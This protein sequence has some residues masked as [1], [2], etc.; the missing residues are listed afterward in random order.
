[1]SRLSVAALAALSVPI[2][3]LS[4][5][6]TG[7]AAAQSAESQEPPPPPPGFESTKGETARSAWLAAT[8]KDS[9]SKMSA[10]EK[11]EAREEIR[12]T[13]LRYGRC[14]AQKDWQCLKNDVFA[15]DFSYLDGPRRKYGWT[16]FIDVMKDAGCYDRVF[17]RVEVYGDE[18]EFSTPTLAR[19]ITAAKF[20]F[21]WM[22]QAGKFPVTGHEVVGPGEESETPTYYYRTFTKVDGKWR[23]R[24]NDH[25]G[26]DMRTK[27][28]THTKYNDRAFV[29]PGESAPRTFEKPLEPTPAPTP[30]R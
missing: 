6:L 22:D 1:M 30:P 5:G 24:T 8:P 18:I 2:G 13:T 28:Y 26:D 29:P 21:A 15:S 11:Q 27:V 19:S 9:L 23:I 25:I 7:S 12:L 4:I 3:I 16:G 20:T 10:S 14:I 17:C